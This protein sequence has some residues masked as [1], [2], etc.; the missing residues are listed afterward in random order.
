MNSSVFP[1][2]L[3]VMV[4]SVFDRR[5]QLAPDF[6]LFTKGRAYYASFFDLK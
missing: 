5:F 3:L 2:I 4:A 6:S 1:F